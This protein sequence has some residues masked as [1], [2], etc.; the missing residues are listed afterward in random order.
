MALENSSK[1]PT[2]E[3]EKSFLV[4]QQFQL[5][6]E[7]DF[8]YFS[9]Y[10]DL[11]G[12]SS[13]EKE[14]T[15][16]EVSDVTSISENTNLSQDEIAKGFELIFNALSSIEN[17]KKASQYLK[18]KI[19]L[20]ELL[21]NADDQMIYDVYVLVNRVLNFMHKKERY[22]IQLPVDIFFNTEYCMGSSFILAFK[23]DDSFEDLEMVKIVGPDDFKWGTYVINKY[24]EIDGDFSQI[25][26]G[27]K[28]TKN[29][30]LQILK[31][32]PNIIEH[33]SYLFKTDCVFS[34]NYV[35]KSDEE[36]HK[37]SK[38]HFQR[39]LERYP[40]MDEEVSGL[41]EKQDKITILSQD[42]IDSITFVQ[43]VEYI[44]LDEIKNGT[45]DTFEELLV[46]T[47]SFQSSPIQDGEA[48]KVL[49]L[50]PP[51]NQGSK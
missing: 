6:V 21:L 29:D 50:T 10:D 28:L 24:I 48:P 20:G 32:Y 14:E 41:E 3:M 26:N 35:D 36:M 40:K 8:S 43:P 25:P 5:T 30:Y 27:I 51:R 15:S 31:K 1:K 22:Y 42:T 7:D 13:D 46:R 23:L 19:T 33:L 37:L 9:R 45:F 34:S 16:S 11:S 18:G 4:D 17:I 2:S 44:T 39:W 49:K 47:N 12:V 38:E